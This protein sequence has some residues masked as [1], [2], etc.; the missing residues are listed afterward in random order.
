MINLLSIFTKGL[1][2]GKFYHHLNICIKT[3][4]QYSVI[5]Y[6]ASVN[7]IED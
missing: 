7:F 4:I 1:K 5:K 3:S 6:Q 2:D